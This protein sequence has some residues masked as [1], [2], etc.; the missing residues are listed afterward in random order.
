MKIIAKEF[1]HMA[2][3]T[4]F[5][6]FMHGLYAHNFF[7]QLLRSNSLSHGR[8][9][10]DF[11]FA[12]FKHNFAIDILSIQLISTLV[13]TLDDFIDGKST[14]F[15]VMTWCRQATSH[16]RNQCWPISLMPYGITWPQRHGN[17]GLLLERNSPNYTRQH[18]GRIPTFWWPGW[19]R[20]CWGCRPATWGCC[21]D[22]HWWT[23]PGVCWRSPGSVPAPRPQ[24]Q[25][26]ALPRQTR[27]NLA[28]KDRAPVSLSRLQTKIH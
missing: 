4:T 16:Y 6:T 2:F 15:Q 9:G 18:Y 23:F 21:Q 11:R 20:L 28:T 8:C 27:Q 22:H 13:S 25:R 10:W 14:L 24:L 26:A 12:N 5:S 7:A 17:R 1:I 19:A 3:A